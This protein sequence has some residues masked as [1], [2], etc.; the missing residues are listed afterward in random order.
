MRELSRTLV[1]NPNT[2]ARV[3]TDLERRGDRPHAAGAGRFRGPPGQ[4]PFA[5]GPPGTAPRGGGP[6]PYRGRPPGLHGRGS[7]RVVA[8]QS[9]QFQWGDESPK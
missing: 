2:I 8:E 1:V 9:G 4:R 6:F 7:V 5:E 3:Y